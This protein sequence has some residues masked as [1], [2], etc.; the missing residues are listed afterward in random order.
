[1]L[2]TMCIGEG[3]TEENRMVAVASASDLNM[4]G[5]V[6]FTTNN[7]CHQPQVIHYCK[8]YSLCYFFLNVIKIEKF[9]ISN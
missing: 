7:T 4:L 1:M 9:Y 8:S 2:W 3:R 5:A 6:C